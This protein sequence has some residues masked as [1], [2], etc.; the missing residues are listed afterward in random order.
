[1]RPRLS[2]KWWLP[3]ASARTI[4]GT[5]NDVGIITLPDGHGRIAIAVYIKKSAKPFEEREHVTA[6]ITR[7]VYDY[8]L[9]E[10]SGHIESAGH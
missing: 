1:M 3:A 9:I 2:R 8:M 5:V 10:S 6:D 7:S 4:A